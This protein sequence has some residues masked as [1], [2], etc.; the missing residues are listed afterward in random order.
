MQRLIWLWLNIGKKLLCVI[1]HIVNDKGFD[2]YL[3][4]IGWDLYVE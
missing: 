2:E 4:V 3:R 1:K